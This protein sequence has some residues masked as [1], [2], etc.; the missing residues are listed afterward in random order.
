MKRLLSLIYLVL[1]C[2]SGFCQPATRTNPTR[3]VLYTCGAN[4]EFFCYEYY[5]NMKVVENK[6]ACITKNKNTGK[7]SFILNGIPVIIAENI[8]VWWIDLT[9]KSK[10][11]Y[12]YSDAD[13]EEYIVIEGQKYGPYDDIYYWLH[14][15]KYY[16]D[17]TPN[18]KLMYNR[19]PL[20]LKEWV[21]IIAMIMMDQFMK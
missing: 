16:W 2:L 6:F 5:S 17:G 9:S 7:L 13:K 1:L 12:T 10:C 4:D 18:L 11:I 8:Y 3:K 21:N 19:I 14:A 20:S 15:C